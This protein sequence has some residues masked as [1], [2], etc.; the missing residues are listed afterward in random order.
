MRYLID[1]NVLIFLILDK[2]MIHRNVKQLFD[3][4]SNSFYISAESVKE[5]IVLVSNNKVRFKQWKTQVQMIEAIEHEFGIKILPIKK[6][7]LLTYARITINE[8]QDHRDPS[9]HI[10]I[11]QA[12]TE[13]IPLI[14]SDHK[15]HFYTE[16]ALDFVYNER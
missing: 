8:A 4:Y 16:Q 14:S 13:G 12:I 10:I 15:F 5:L 1:T 9:D 2:E 7:H 3:D 11:S 6:E